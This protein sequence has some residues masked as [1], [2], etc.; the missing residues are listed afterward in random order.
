MEQILLTDPG[1]RILT[2]SLNGMKFRADLEL[3]EKD[4]DPKIYEIV[5]PEIIFSM[6]ATFFITCFG[7]SV[8]L[9]GRHGFLKKYNFKSS[10]VIQV[11]VDYGIGR[12][13]TD[14]YIASK[15]KE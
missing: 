1:R 14:Q 9:L 11:N 3:D 8:R 4:N 2:G 5:I 6:T 15:K 10:K 7:P 13:E 12:I